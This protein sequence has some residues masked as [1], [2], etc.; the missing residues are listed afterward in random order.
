MG[1]PPYPPRAARPA[2]LTNSLFVTAPAAKQHEKEGIAG[3]P[4]QVV[5]QVRDT[6]ARQ[7]RGRQASVFEEELRAEG[8]EIV[9]V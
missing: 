1:S 8:L 6:F 9:A 4:P 3:L 2:T 5:E 7:L